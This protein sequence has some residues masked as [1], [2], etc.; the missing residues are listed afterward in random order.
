MVLGLVQMVLL[1]DVDNGVLTSGMV[2]PGRDL[3]SETQ[4]GS[5]CV[6]RR[7]GGPGKRY[8]K[9]RPALGGD[10]QVPHP[11]SQTQGPKGSI[12]QER[13]IRFEPLPTDVLCLSHACCSSSTRLTP[14]LS[15]ISDARDVTI[16]VSGPGQEEKVAFVEVE[17]VKRRKEGEDEL[18][19]L[20]AQ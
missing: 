19:F 11:A 20:P 17:D 9:D 13:G 7:A 18:A 6:Q 3:M 4:Y 12:A 5:A 2:V 10:G 1:P 16:I 8:V 14:V 15:K